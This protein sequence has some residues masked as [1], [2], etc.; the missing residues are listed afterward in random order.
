MIRKYQPADADT[1][2]SVWQAASRIAHPF[3]EAGFMAQ[4]AENM[5][6]LY[7]PNAE[8]WVTEENRVAVGFISLIGNS[9]GGLFLDPS[10]HGRGMG[11]AM[12]DYAV[13]L[14][15]ALDVEV[16]K[17]N[18]IGRRF[19]ARCGFVEFERYLHKPTGEVTLKLQLPDH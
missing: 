4:E 17:R 8:T 6:R 5:R 13:H 2:V 1:L 3:L 16:F 10:H 7:L 19:Y 11:K 18:D 9:I 15:G 14:K 12:V